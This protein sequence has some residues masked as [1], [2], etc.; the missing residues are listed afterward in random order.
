MCISPDTKEQHTENTQKNEESTNHWFLIT[1]FFLDLNDVLYTTILLSI[2]GDYNVEPE[3][4][5]KTQFFLS[6]TYLHSPV[7]I[8]FTRKTK[9]LQCH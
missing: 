9:I 1:C 6:H 3:Q 2:C 8:Q 7:N 4:Y 5:Y